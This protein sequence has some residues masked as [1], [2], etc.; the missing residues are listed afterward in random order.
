MS[1]GFTIYADSNVTKVMKDIERS[2]TEMK[3]TVE[4]QTRRAEQSMERMGENMRKVGERVAEIFAAREILRFGREILDL[5]AEFQGYNNVIKFS[6]RNTVD[7]ARNFD[8]LGNIITRLHL[9][10]RETFQGFSEMQA[11]LIGTGIE[12]EKLRKVFEG[13]A[14][15][16]SVLHLNQ[17]TLEMILYDFK[18]IGERGLNMRNWRSL[19]GWLPGA[20]GVVREHFGKTFEELEKEKMDP[21]K[22]LQGFSE[23]LQKHF[24]SGLANVS[25]SLQAVMNDTQTAWT[26]TMLKMGENLE[27]VFVKIMKGIQDAFNSGPVRFF[28]NNIKEIVTVVGS[29]VNMWMLYKAGIIA[30]EFAMKAFT[31]TTKLATYAQYAFNFGLRTAIQDSAALQ[32]AIQNIG[33]GAMAIG[34]GL[35]IEKWYQL[36]REAEETM[37]RMTNIK[38]IAGTFN[39]LDQE[40]ADLNRT[41]ANLKNLSPEQKA[42]ALSWATDLN[43]K[44]AD[45]L[46]MKAQPSYQA[47]KDTLAT[48]PKVPAYTGEE[49]SIRSYVLRYGGLQNT[50][51]GI[52]SRTDSLGRIVQKETDI[53]DK[54]ADIIK[55]LKGQ[56]V[57]PEVVKSP[58][59]A[60][61]ITDSSLKTMGLAGA[62][63]GLGE[64]KMIHIT[65]G[66]I[67]RN[68][69]HTPKELKQAGQEAV[70]VILR[71]LNNAA[72]GQSRTM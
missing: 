18:E 68:E 45:E 60:N 19:V 44:A 29:L 2:I 35:V 33:F 72:Y 34:L 6:S 48:F 55:Q 16:S 71:A 25:H 64:A 37:D 21:G 65:I 54:T 69:L 31:V 36:N 40:M 15:A 66:T 22:F 9:P 13:I 63:G 70:E 28:V 58:P 49:G 59:H 43:K 32:G 47:S 8:F 61:D 23:G 41:M 1:Y 30:S 12:G 62:K 38:A 24:S 42:T 17:H 10:M 26:A 4:A 5:T 11:G 53:R 57:K 52:T 14:T 46:A 20:G 56:G 39:T 3:N 27:P 50:I 51:N 7:A 67:Q